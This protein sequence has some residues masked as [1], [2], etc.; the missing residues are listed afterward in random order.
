ME[1]GILIHKTSSVGRSEV[2][3]TELEEGDI[4]LSPSS[5]D[6]RLLAALHDEYRYQVVYY[7]PFEAVTTTI[8]K[9]AKRTPWI[10]VAGVNS[11]VESYACAGV[12]YKD[13][14]ELTRKHTAIQH[15]RGIQHVILDGVPERKLRQIKESV[16]AWGRRLVVLKI[17]RD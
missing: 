17:M 15:L 11:N 2:S 3:I 8:Q 9:L 10:L 14:R 7:H 13:Y 4:L 6:Q 1:G 5:I 16:L 12:P